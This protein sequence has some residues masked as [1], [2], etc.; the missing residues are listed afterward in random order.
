MNPSENRSIQTYSLQAENGLAIELE[1]RVRVDA[2][3]DTSAG[4]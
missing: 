2:H 4:Q 1:A 3:V